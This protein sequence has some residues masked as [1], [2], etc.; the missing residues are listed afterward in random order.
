M[1]PHDHHVAP[2]D[3]EAD[4][5]N[6]FLDT[7][8][9]GNA[10]PTH[11]LPPTLATS[12][13]HVHRFADE[14][15]T[16]RLSP[17]E[18]DRLWE[19]LMQT[20]TAPDA[21]PFPF[22]G[23]FRR[24]MAVE[25]GLAEPLGASARHREARLRLVGSAS[26][27]AP[28]PSTPTIGTRRDLGPRRRWV[29]HG[30]PIVELLGVAALIIGLV[31]VIIGGFGGDDGSRP[32]VIPM[33]GVGIATP[34][35]RSDEVATLP[36]PGQTGVMPGPGID[37]NPELIWRV[38]IEDVTSDL[39]VS[40]GT[41]VRSHFSSE[42][43]ADFPATT[44]PWTIEALSARAG[45]PIWKTEIE[46]SGVQ[47]G[48]VWQGTIVLV[49]SGEY[50]PIRVGNEEIG[51]QGQGFGIGLDL[52]TGAVQWSTRVTDDSAVPAS[53]YSPTLANDQ[54]FVPTSQG[55]LYSVNP[56]SGSIS[57][58]TAI[59]D[60]SVRQAVLQSF[61]RPAVADDIVTVYSWATGSAYAFDTS[62]GK[63]QWEIELSVDPA[64]GYS[65]TSIAGPVMA[66]GSV[67]FTSADYDSENSTGAQSLIA[68]EAESGAMRWTTDLAP[69]DLTTGSRPYGVGQP[70]VAGDHLLVSIADDD[71]FGLTAFSVETGEQVWQSSFGDSLFSLLSI[72]DDTAYV[73]RVSGALTGIDIQTGDE[74][75]SVETGGELHSAPY[76]VDGM[77]YQ[78]GQDG[79]LYAL[80]EG[81]TEVATP[82]A[83]TAISGLA[84]CDVEP[85]A[86]PEEV[87]ATA[88]D[89][90]PAAT[91]AESESTIAWTDLP[92]GA[93]ADADV[94]TAIQ[95][96]VS[97]ITTCTRT[98]DPA[99]VA[100][101]Y[102]DDF[103]SRPYN[104]NAE[105]AVNGYFTTSEIPVM[106]GDLRMMDDGRVGMI[107]TEG[108]ISRQIGQNQ[109]TLYLFAEQPDGQWLIDEVV[110]VNNSGEAPQG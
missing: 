101:F 76:I 109:A 98:G 34:E 97:G 99:Q 51:D 94:A 91:L 56:T 75:W 44:N 58:S 80:G 90:T 21:I 52:A 72:A 2:S 19:D 17:T 25:S 66:G 49:A 42:I 11:D 20:H 33:A 74:L 14:H 81:G 85:R 84:S 92:V 104:L 89:R 106:S 45:T 102:T 70:Y 53:V 105:G 32:A 88:A 31:S 79:Q 6:R 100:A 23:P 16:P 9:A 43:P 36:D 4:E 57:W 22:P 26:T 30:W 83:S 62:S 5:L 77:V 59:G 67:Y 24:P 12:A 7:L 39:F 65:R 110:I 93:P 63:Q 64:E 41:L 87:F 61:S 37:G 96:T 8:V 55:M 13:R 71:G 46:A 1:M 18:S 47:I 48:G 107:A 78:A 108:L 28:A 86:A 95:Q 68:V 29:R 82:G 10:S 60:Q 40:D 27:A 3:H 103:F 35:Q 73:A 54:L 15:A 38:P 69:I 50:G